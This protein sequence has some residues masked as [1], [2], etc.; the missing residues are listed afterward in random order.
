MNWQFHNDFDRCIQLYIIF[1]SDKC[2][3]TQINTINCTLNLPKHWHI[4]L[5]QIK[6]KTNTTFHFLDLFVNS[7]GN[8]P[9]TCCLI[10]RAW[11]V[12]KWYVLLRL[13]K[14]LRAISVNNILRRSS[15]LLD[16]HRDIS[17]W[18]YCRMHPPTASFLGGLR[19]YK[20]VLL[21]EGGVGK[22]GEYVPGADITLDWS[23]HDQ[24][25]SRAN[26]F[27]RKQLNR[28]RFLD[29]F[30][31]CIKLLITIWNCC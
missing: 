1:A 25:N 23:S 16:K 8:Q 13:L 11:P 24:R 6:L 18:N 27:T 5:G 17:E 14:H 9:I 7:H 3:V 2:N 4:I 19:M 30:P 12:Y 29:E 20:I 21:G 15:L 31:W 22:S 28:N 26:I 10:N